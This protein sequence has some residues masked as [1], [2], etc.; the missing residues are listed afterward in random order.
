M[1][2]GTAG[3]LSPNHRG[4]M[5]HFR[6]EA[7]TNQCALQDM[8]VESVQW[9]FLIG[10]DKRK[11]KYKKMSRHQLGMKHM[12]QVMH[13]LVVDLPAVGK[14]LNRHTENLMAAKPGDRGEEEEGELLALKP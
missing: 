9:V 2:G 1:G 11:S 7:I 14:V 5:P 10:A 12:S 8:G 3:G 4:A 6:G 13:D